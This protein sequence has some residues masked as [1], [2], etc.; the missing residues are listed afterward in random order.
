MVNRAYNVSKGYKI[1]AGWGVGLN[2]PNVHF[3]FLFSHSTFA[4]VTWSSDPMKMVVMLHEHRFENGCQYEWPADY[5]P[6]VTHLDP[7][8]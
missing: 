3:Q 2:K 8:F 6:L 5:G 4:I 7:L 1:P